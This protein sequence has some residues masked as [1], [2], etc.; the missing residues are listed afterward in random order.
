M[1]NTQ[2]NT[3]LWKLFNKIM[4]YIMFVITAPKPRVFNYPSVDGMSKTSNAKGFN[5]EFIFNYN[6]MH[7]LESI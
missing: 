7:I 4:K 5:G 6:F 2:R 3:E 1:Q